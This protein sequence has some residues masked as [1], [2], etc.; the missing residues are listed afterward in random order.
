LAEFLY[1]YKV[2][3]K[4]HNFSFVKTIIQGHFQWK[5][6]LRG[7][8]DEHEEAGKAERGQRG[9]GSCGER[10]SRGRINK[11]G[12]GFRPSDVAFLP[13]DFGR[14]S[15]DRRPFSVMISATER[16]RVALTN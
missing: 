6:L 9:G 4:M 13:K 1:I 12:R 3:L 10:Q 14:R 8:T 7:V 15:R 5:D 16:L 11:S 2:D